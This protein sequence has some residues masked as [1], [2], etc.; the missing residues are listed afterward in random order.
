MKLFLSRFALLGLI[1]SVAVTAPAAQKV[2]TPKTQDAKQ[3]L[4]QAQSKLKDARSALDKAQKAFRQAETAQQATTAALAKARQSVYD[5]HA[6][7]IGLTAASAERDAARTQ[8]N[9]ARKALQEDLKAQPDY[10]KAIRSADEAGARFG[11]LNDDA[12][13]SSER[14]Q[15]LSVELAAVMRRPA[16][17][18]RERESSDAGL[19]EAQARFRAADQQV[20]ALQAHLQK[21]M[22]A[23]PAVKDAQE[24]LKDAASQL[25]KARSSFNQSQQQFNSAQS[26][27]NREQQQYQQAQNQ[28]RKK[29]VKN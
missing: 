5:R 18:E 11:G 26:A 2:N 12:S 22:D 23:D 20:S 8:V 27:V 21:E 24:K 17:M 7:K 1:V 16:E 9:A 6:G 15:K 28:A 10:Q 4:D 3:Q 25:A 19:Q 13:L 14:R 29:R